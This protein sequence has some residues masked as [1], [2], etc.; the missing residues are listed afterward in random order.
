MLA[1]VAAAVTSIHL[2]MVAIHFCSLVQHYFC[3]S[4]YALHWEGSDV[5]QGF[6]NG[7]PR[8][9]GGPPRHSRGSANLKP[10]PAKL[11]RAN[12]AA[13]YTQTFPITLL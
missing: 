4:C 11:I 12:S 6:P 10:S 1:I 13:L 5:E 2:G 7:G 9:T 3:H 8:P